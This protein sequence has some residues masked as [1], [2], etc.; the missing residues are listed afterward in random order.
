MIYKHNQRVIAS[1]VILFLRFD[2]QNLFPKS[3]CPLFNFI[4]FRD[5]TEI[6]QD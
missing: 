1:F 2:A 4:C 3:S 5:A 6:S